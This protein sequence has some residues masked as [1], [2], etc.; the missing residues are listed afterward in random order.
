MICC[1]LVGVDMPPDRAIFVNVMGW[2]SGYG[3]HL[4]AEHAEVVEG[5]AAAAGAMPH[6]RQRVQLPR[7]AGWGAEAMHYLRPPV[8]LPW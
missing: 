2:E 7:R 4:L 5:W 3:T 8:R 1:A 6:L